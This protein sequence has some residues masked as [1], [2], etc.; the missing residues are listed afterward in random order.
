M[1]KLSELLQNKHLDSALFAFFNT[2]LD[3]K[4]ESF[5]SFVISSTYQLSKFYEINEK[6]KLEFFIQTN[7]NLS[8]LSNLDFSGKFGK[9]EV[10]IKNDLNYTIDE[11]FNALYKNI[12][13]LG[14]NNYDSKEFEKALLNAIFMLNGSPDFNRNLMAVD[15]CSNYCTK[16]YFSKYFKLI[17]HLNQ[18]FLNLNFREL[19][20]QF[21]NNERKRNMQFR[22][23]LAYFYKNMQNLNIYKI[24]LLESN[25]EKIKP[26][27]QKEESSNEIIKRFE[28]YNNLILNKQA[29]N[30]DKLRERLGFEKNNIESKNVRNA[31]II[32]LARNLLKDECVGCLHKY[33]IKDRSFK[34]RQG[35]YYLEIHHNVAFSFNKNLCDDID[36]LVKLCPTCHK[37]LSKNRADENY[38]KEII[39]SI[40]KHS[41]EAKDFAKAI[42]KIENDDELIEYIYETL[43]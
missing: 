43:A 23:N 42:S 37:A 4:I 28:F 34:T 15:I 20:P 14:F 13:F 6:E 32:L 24:K 8:K 10:R 26:L 40:L 39:E 21:T 12:I 25:K 27:S 17:L 1:Y 3:R 16:N 19:Q 41:S 30:I 38:Q 11:Y 2:R 18:N 22:V 9:H 33:D 29:I 31:N 5:E 7:K 35:F 36:N